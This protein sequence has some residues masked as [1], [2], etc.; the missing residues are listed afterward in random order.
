MELGVWASASEE[1]L[2]LRQ[3][4]FFNLH[5]YFIHSESTNYAHEQYEYNKLTIFLGI[6]DVF[7]QKM[8]LIK[9]SMVIL[10]N[11]KVV[12]VTRRIW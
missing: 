8:Q 11:V 12:L 1:K 4:L 5:C 6:T 10:F 3:A 7:C 9:L 2:I